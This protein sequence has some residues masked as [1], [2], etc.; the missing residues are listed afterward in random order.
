MELAIIEEK[1]QEKEERSWGAS[2]SGGPWTSLY[3]QCKH[4]HTAA[5]N[6]GKIWGEK[7]AKPFT[8]QKYRAEFILQVLSTVVIG[9]LRF[10]HLCCK[11]HVK[12]KDDSVS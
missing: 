12:N 10:K 5:P 7:T 8:Y 11:V 3:K 1:F 9:K 6:A 4:V 2:D